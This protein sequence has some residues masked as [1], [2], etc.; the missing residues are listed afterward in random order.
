MIVLNKLDCVSAK[1]ENTHREITKCLAHGK[2]SILAIVIMDIPQWYSSR[3]PQ[4]SNYHNKVSH[5]NFMVSQ[6]IYKLYLY[7][8]AFY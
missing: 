2:H 4:E 1:W 7:Y 6:C 5:T 8:I 3:P